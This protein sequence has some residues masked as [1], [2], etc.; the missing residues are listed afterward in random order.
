L[1]KIQTFSEI[2]QRHLKADESIHTY[3]E[4]IRS[5]AKRMSMLIKSVLNYSNLSKSKEQFSPVNLNTL[6]EHVVADFEVV[7][8]EKQAIV[9]WNSLP[10][11]KGISAQLSQ[12]FANLLS[13]S[14]K[15]ADKKP[16]IKITAQI[17]TEK[18][19]IHKPE[20]FAPGKYHEIAFADNG[21]G[22]EQQ[23]ADQI[24]TMF[25]R[26]HARQQYS[27]TGIGLALCKKIM[28]NHSGH[29]AAKA[30]PGEGATFYVYLPV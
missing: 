11:V 1:R 23:Y 27:G 10:D 21:I 13:N 17:V 6:I 5:S 2:I 18:E 9:E 16:A 12:L 15:F 22:F 26:L 8:A 19:V 3:F 30:V 14:L 4:K 20:H 24:F 25:Q 7:I 29:I 28:E